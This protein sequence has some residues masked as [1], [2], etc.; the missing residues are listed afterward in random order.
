MLIGSVGRLRR[1][2]GSVGRLRRGRGGWLGRL[3][4]RGVV[5]APSGGTDLSYTGTDLTELPLVQETRR[6]I[7]TAQRVTEALAATPW[8]TGSSTSSR[9]KW[10][11]G[12]TRTSCGPKEF[13]PKTASCW[14]KSVKNSIT[15]SEDSRRHNLRP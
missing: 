4:T 1:V 7:H 8:V 9:T 11:A 14:K 12:S 15:I 5:V 10:T 3:G 6:V 2:D 13:A